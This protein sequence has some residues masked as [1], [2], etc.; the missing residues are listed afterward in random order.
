ML[1]I[2]IIDKTAGLTASHERHQAIAALPDVDLHVLGPRH[3]IENGREVHWQPPSDTA[4]TVHFGKVIFKDKYARA[5][6]YSGLIQ[7][8][9]DAKPDIIQ[10]LEEPWSFT[11]AQTLAVAKLYAPQA[12]L[13]FYTWENIE[14]GWNYP[15]RGA[16][17]YWIIDQFMHNYSHGAVCAT[18]QAENVLQQKGFTKPTTTISYGI[19]DFFLQTSPKSKPS[20]QT[21]TIG[22]VG[23]LLS[24]K[25]VDLLL[26]TLYNITDTQL[27]IIGSGS[28][29]MEFKSIAEQWGVDNRIKWVPHVAETDLPSYLQQ[30][31]VLVLPSRTTPGWKEQLGRVL[32]EA[33]AVGVPV[34]GSSSGA[35]P[36]VIGN[37]GMI[38]KEDDVDDLCTKIQQ[39]MNKPELSEQMANDGK[40]RV[41]QHFKWSI[42]AELLISFYRNKFL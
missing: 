35:I 4:Y 13:L 31:D 6:Y 14:R 12:K 17:L 24:M 19:P 32:I 10:L 42:F 41:N 25:G 38:F 27:L 16:F 20:N 33:M 36:E 29:E 30:M 37:A 23:R 21:F 28:D 26:H 40:L 7:A 8:L 5:T 9:K 34:I 2:L 15:S 22:Y 1:R 39:L 11:A 18:K 3:W